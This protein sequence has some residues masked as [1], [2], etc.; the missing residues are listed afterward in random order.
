MY[1]RQYVSY[2]WIENPWGHLYK[3]VDGISVYNCVPYVCNSDAY[4]TDE[5][6]PNYTSLGVILP[7]PEGYQKTLLPVGRGFLPNSLRGHKDTHIGDYYAIRRSGWRTAMSGG[8]AH[9]GA[10]AGVFYLNIETWPEF[11]GRNIT[12]R[13]CY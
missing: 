3:W 11:A 1:K 4:F 2:R 12:G 10:M 9:S 5:I 7:S 8:G 6:A 13:L